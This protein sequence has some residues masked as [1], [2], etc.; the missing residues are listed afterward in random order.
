MG[1]ILTDPALKMGENHGLNFK[2]L[3]NL[4]FASVYIIKFIF[5]SH[6]IAMTSIKPTSMY[7]YI[8]ALLLSFNTHLFHENH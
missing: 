1:F 7:K 2:K 6:T 8:C 5:K 4:S 3:M